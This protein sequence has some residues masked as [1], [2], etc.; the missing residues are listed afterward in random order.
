MCLV[1]NDSTVYDWNDKGINSHLKIKIANN[2]K[3]EGHKYMQ[4]N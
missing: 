2:K 1:E 4:G 3:R